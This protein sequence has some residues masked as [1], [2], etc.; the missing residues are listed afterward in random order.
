MIVIIKVRHLQVGDR[1]R[2]TGDLDVSDEFVEIEGIRE[3]RGHYILKLRGYHQWE[4]HGGCRVEI[5][6]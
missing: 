3:V 6:K 5:Q 4:L 1:V 2:Y